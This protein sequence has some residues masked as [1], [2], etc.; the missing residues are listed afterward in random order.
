[1]KFSMIS[2]QNAY[3]INMNSNYIFALKSSKDLEWILEQKIKLTFKAPNI[4]FHAIIRF[5]ISLKCQTKKI[6]TTPWPPAWLHCRAVLQSPASI[7]TTALS[8][9]LA[10]MQLRSAWTKNVS[11]RTCFS[12]WPLNANAVNCTKNV[13]WLTHNA[14]DSMS[15]QRY[16]IRSP[17]VTQSRPWLTKKSRN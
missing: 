13:P 12:A 2:I 6:P 16:T 3:L 14:W 11:R 10:T 9:H 5:L 8:A 15:T 1:M 17:C 7:Q 4:L